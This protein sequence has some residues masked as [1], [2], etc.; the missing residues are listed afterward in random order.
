M[1][2]LSSLLAFAGDF[3]FVFIFLAIAL[4][5]GFFFGRTKLIAIMIDIYIARALVAVIPADWIA[6]VTYTDTI[7]FVL[8]FV[9]LLLVDYR[10]FDLHLSSRM[11]G[12]FWRVVIMGVLVTGMFASSLFSYL[13]Q[14]TVL[15]Y[16]SETLYSYFV[17]DIAQ[18][19]WLIAPLIMLGFINYRLRD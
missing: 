7:I 3:S 11:S 10:L 8:A 19:F 18:M 1:D 16:V 13:P 9:F 4:G 17:S 2:F 5:V 6:S 14:A 12:F 15:Q